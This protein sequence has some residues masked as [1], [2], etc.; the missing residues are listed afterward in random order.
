VIQAWDFAP[1]DNFVAKMQAAS[2]QAARTLAVL[3]P[4]YLQSRFGTEEW[5]AALAGGT[6]LPV[7]VREVQLGGILA[8]QVYVDLVGLSE[9]AAAEQLLAALGRKGRRKPSGKPGFPASQPRFPAA[10]PEIWNVP[11]ARNPN[12]TGRESELDRLVAALNDRYVVAL[13]GLGGMGKSQLAIQLAHR[14][15]PQLEIV[16]WVAAEEPT[17][18]IRDL[19]SWP[20]DSASRPKRNPSPPRPPAVAS[21]S[22]G[23]GC[24]SSTTPATRPRCGRSFRRPGPVGR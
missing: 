19:R 22:A 23:D 10:L 2:V 14:C 18:I 13:T 4:D 5:T 15:A 1:G 20:G 17:T 3:S 21:S 8:V 9:A 24:S 6:L 11:A 16:W 12:F 7:R